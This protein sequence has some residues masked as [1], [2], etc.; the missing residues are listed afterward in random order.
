[1]Q[2]AARDLPEEEQQSVYQAYHERWAAVPLQVCL[3]LRGFYVKIGQV[4]AGIPD[5]VPE[6]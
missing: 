1:M 3:D 5:I 4:V 6:P 2:W